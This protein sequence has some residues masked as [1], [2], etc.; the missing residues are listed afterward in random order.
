M[1]GEMFYNQAFETHNP[2]LMEISQKSPKNL[3]VASLSFHGLK[4]QF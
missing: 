4:T 1:P 3:K 2:N